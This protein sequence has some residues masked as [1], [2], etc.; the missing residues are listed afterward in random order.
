MEGRMTLCN[1]SIEAGA[2]AG[3]VS[4]DQTTIAY[5]AN[6]PAGPRGHDFDRAADRWL[7][8]ASDPDAQFDRTELISASE[9]EPFVTWGT[10]P[11]MVAPVT[12]RVPRLSELPD[13]ASRAAA[14]RALAY[15]GLQEEIAIQ[16][17][18]VARVFIGSCTNSRIE[19]LRQAAAVAAGRRV[20]PRVRAMVVPGSGTVKR[21]AE[22]EG[23][24]RIFKDSGFE[25]LEAGC[26]MCLGMNPDIL[27]PKERCAS[28]SNR[29]FE[30]RQGVGGRTHLVSPAMAAGA[31]LYGHFVD[32]RQLSTSA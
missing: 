1:M 25:W 30:G 29:N 27:M 23:L 20:H 7:G 2:R 11:A 13:D 15:M 10:T 17:I 5:L 31:A 6:R 14:A 21:Q 18:A 28:T 32:V 26:S 24:D 8:F 3:L 12:G 19:D 16:D 4:P 9:L 22:R